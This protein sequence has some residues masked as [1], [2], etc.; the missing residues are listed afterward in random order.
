MDC[1][2][3]VG[4][5]VL[6]HDSLIDF[7]MA[8]VGALCNCRCCNNGSCKLCLV[9]EKIH[10]RAGCLDIFDKH[11]SYCLPQLWRKLGSN[12]GRALLHYF[13]NKKARKRIITKRI[14]SRHLYF[15][16]NFTSTNSKLPC[17][18][19]NNCRLEL[20]LQWQCSCFHIKYARI[21]L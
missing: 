10:V 1:L 16:H 13:G 17:K 9:N 8:A 15:R 5:K 7:S 6:Y 11:S 12:S 20:V 3:S 21:L 14:I 2:V 19:L 4:M 18:Q